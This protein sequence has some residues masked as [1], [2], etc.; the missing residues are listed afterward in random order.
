MRVLA[1]RLRDFFRSTIRFLKIVGIFLGTAVIFIGGE[2]VQQ[3]TITSVF[4]GIFSV[5]VTGGLILSLSKDFQQDRL[6]K[7]VE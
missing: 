6:K 7:I 2:I 1:N 5:A 4:I 3:R